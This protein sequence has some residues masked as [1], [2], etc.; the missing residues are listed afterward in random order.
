M[1]LAAAY[2]RTSDPFVLALFAPLTLGAY[3][4]G[5]VAM[6]GANARPLGRFSS[7]LDMFYAAFNR[8]F[9]QVFP[10]LRGLFRRREQGKKVSPAFW[11]VL[12]AIRCCFWW[13]PASSAGAAFEGL[14]SGF[15]KHIP[16]KFRAYHRPVLGAHRV[17]S[18]LR[19]GGEPPGQRPTARPE[20]PGGEHPRRRGQRLPGSHFGGVS[21]VSLE[22]DRL[23]FQRF[24][25]HFAEKISRQRTMPAG[26]SLKWP[27][28]W[29]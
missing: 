28:S 2:G 25:G 3:F 14:L 20:G 12:I 9:T 7:L 5:L 29:S 4:L 21:P 10:A 8:T 22:P 26:A 6:T 19:P 16:K 1:V 17:R 27:S 23:L 15:T 24:P 18:G 11:G 13:S